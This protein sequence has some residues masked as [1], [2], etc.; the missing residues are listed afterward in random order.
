M[1][2]FAMGLHENKAYSIKIQTNQWQ[3]KKNKIS[4]TIQVS[5]HYLSS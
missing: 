5:S 2:G 3:N 1:L 4:K